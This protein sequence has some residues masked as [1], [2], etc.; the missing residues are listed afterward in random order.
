[1]GNDMNTRQ[2]DR[3]AALLLLGTIALNVALFIW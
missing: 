1:M 2:A 3:C